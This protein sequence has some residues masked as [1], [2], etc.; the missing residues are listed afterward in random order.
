MTHRKRLR[1]SQIK[2]VK[3][4][5]VESLARRSMAGSL[6][7]GFA[8][9]PTQK[10]L[11]PEEIATTTIEADDLLAARAQAWGLLVSSDSLDWIEESHHGRG[12]A[13]WRATSK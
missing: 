4:W 9:R 13:D 3:S 8:A 5:G 7:T 11:V 2:A 12:K 1:E 6:R 10:E